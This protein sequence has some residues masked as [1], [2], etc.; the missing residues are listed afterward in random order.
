[1]TSMVTDIVFDVVSGKALMKAAKG[2][3]LISKFQQIKGKATKF[4]DGICKKTKVANFLS[5]TGGTV[6]SGM[7]NDY[8][9]TGKVDLKNLGLDAIGGTIKGTFGTA[10][11]EWGK[12][13]VPRRS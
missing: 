3:K 9:T 11:T 6:L 4:W 7:V 13:F 12:N 10:F 8:L 2:G 1:M 5:Q